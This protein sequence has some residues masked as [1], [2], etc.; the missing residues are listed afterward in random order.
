MEF[1]YR[2]QP[3]MIGVPKWFKRSGIASNLDLYSSHLVFAFARNP[4]LITYKAH[5]VSQSGPYSAK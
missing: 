5:P 4:F 2:K 3:D 1:S